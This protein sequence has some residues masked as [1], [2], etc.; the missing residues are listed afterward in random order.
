MTSKGDTLKKPIVILKFAVYALLNL[1]LL[2]SATESIQATIFKVLAFCLFTFVFYSNVLEKLIYNN[3]LYQHAEA[4]YIEELARYRGTLNSSHGLPLGWV[5]M[6]DNSLDQHQYLETGTK[7]DDELSFIVDF[8]ESGYL[9]IEGTPTEPKI[10]FYPK[11]TTLVETDQ[12]K[13]KI[14]RDGK[15]IFNLR[16]TA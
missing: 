8:D 6:Y 5:I 7:G 9:Q 16:Y 15:E 2:I 1:I 14:Y 10:D 11:A 4:G 3:E 13:I 12:I